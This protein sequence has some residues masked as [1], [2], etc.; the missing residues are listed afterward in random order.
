MC[1]SLMGA[2]DM[3]KKLVGG[4]IAVLAV[5]ALVAAVVAMQKDNTTTDNTTDESSHSSNSSSSTDEHANTDP[6]T[7]ESTAETDAVEITDFAF[8]PATIKVKKGTTVKWTNKDSVA[9][10]VTAKD[11]S[12]GPDSELLDQGESYSFT[13]NEV[14]TFE[15]FCKPHPNM[16]AKVIVE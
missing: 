9:H 10:T 8:S 4:V 3:N 1:V 2:R 12:K 16:Q 5:V 13:F 14:G 6:G 15:Y 7:T 11:T